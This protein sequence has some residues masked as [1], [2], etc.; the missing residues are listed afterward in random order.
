MDYTTLGRTGLKVSRAGLGAGGGSRMGRTIGLSAEQSAALIRL[1]YELGINVI[2]TAE[3]YGTEEIVGLALKDLPRDQV[4]VSTKHYIIKRGHEYSTQDVLDG[5]DNSLRALGTDYVDLFFVH[6]L[7][8]RSLPRAVGDVIPALKREQERGKFRFLGATAAGPPPR[9]G[10]AS[11]G[12][13]P[14]RRFDAGFFGA[15]SERPAIHL[16]DDQR[17]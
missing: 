13:R 14:D 6:G 5:L 4:V 10:P 16:P 7:T 11:D 8:L 9:H 3:D 15:Q 17:K 1:A 12:R 2:D